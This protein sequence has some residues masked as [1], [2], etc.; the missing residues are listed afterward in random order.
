M[1]LD[2]ASIDIHKGSIRAST[3]KFYLMNGEN[4]ITLYYTNTK[5]VWFKRMAT[6][7]CQD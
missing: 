4:I 7:L 3:T 6:F 2:S 1:L 5:I